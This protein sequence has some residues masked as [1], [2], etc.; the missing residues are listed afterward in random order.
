VNAKLKLNLLLVAVSLSG[1]VAGF[2]TAMAVTN[3]TMP[4][5]WNVSELAQAPTEDS[6][7]WDCATQGNRS[8]GPG[9]DL[10]SPFERCLAAMEAAEIPADLWECRQPFVL[11]TATGP[12]S[13]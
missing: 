5:I 3:Q 9:F 11:P 6:P 1:M 10:T 4:P 8:C 2:T 12:D 13:P 7:G